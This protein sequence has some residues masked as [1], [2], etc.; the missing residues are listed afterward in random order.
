MDRFLLGEER[1]EDGPDRPV[2]K[3]SRRGLEFELPE[4]GDGAA[5]KKE[6]ANIEQLKLK[7]EG[8]PA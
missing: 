8:R 5:P 7:I 6:N 3:T 2:G 4:P 1:P